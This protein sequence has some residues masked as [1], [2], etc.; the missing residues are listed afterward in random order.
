MPVTRLGLLLS[1]LLVAA[2]V[3]AQE[4]DPPAAAP[5]APP[6]PTRRGTSD[7][8]PDARLDHARGQTPE[9]WS[10]AT[11][12][13]IMA[14]YPDYREAY[15]KPWS[16]VQGYMF[17]GFEILYRATGDRR[18]LD[19]MKRYVDAFVDEQGLFTGDKL[20]NLDN[21][22]TG[23]TVAALYEHTGDPRYKVAATQLLRALDHYPRSDGQFW[24][25]NKSPN[26]WI[27]GVFMGQMFVLRYGRSVGERDRCLDEAVRQITAHARHCEKG[28]RGLYLHAWSEKPEDTNWADPK[29][30]LSPEVWSEGLGWYALV[31]PETLAAL[32]KEHRGRGP[33]EAIFRKLAD[34]L[35]RTQDPKTGGWFMI[36]DKGQE[37]DNWIDPSGTAMFVYSLQ[38]GIELG[39]L[40]AKRF[41]PVVEKAYASLLRF[42]SI[43][44]RGL[45]DVAGGGDGISVKKDYATYVS[46]KRVLN[47]KEA[48][49]G[50]LWASAILERPRLE[51]RSKTRPRSR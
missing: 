12:E 10:I 38:R 17:F 35:A 40:D 51:T 39:L 22:M 18:Y 47:A 45:V 31:V 5:T 8:V 29:T 48:V 13:T 36:V 44:D 16:Y 3:D 26:M 11:A 32:P 9:F 20:T 15:W 42:V 34:G 27:D 7:G 25:G 46:V 50:F 14:R 30:G 23:T 1:A 21:L 4:S 41:G 6:S 28:D 2:R 37:P 43:N 33:V 24:H 49:A 19:Y